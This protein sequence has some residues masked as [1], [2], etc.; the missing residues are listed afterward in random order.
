[1]ER[2]FT[3]EPTMPARRANLLAAAVTVAVVVAVL[4]GR[5]LHPPATSRTPPSEPDSLAPA[6]NPYDPTRGPTGSS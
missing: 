5:P 6:A 4:F 2:P 1:M 3:R